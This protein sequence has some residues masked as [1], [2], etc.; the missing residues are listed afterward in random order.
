MCPSVIF[1]LF[2]LLYLLLNNPGPSILLMQMLSTS[3]F[4]LEFLQE[5][6]RSITLST[7]MMVMVT[8]A[9]VTVTFNPQWPLAIRPTCSLCIN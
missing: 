3:G 8:T 2:F 7:R 5:G 9:A 4:S 1:L 6:V